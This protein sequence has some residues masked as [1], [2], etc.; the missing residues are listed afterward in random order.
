MRRVENGGKPKG[1]KWWRFFT[2]GGTSSCERVFSSFLG[3]VP[4]LL[5]LFTISLKDD[6]HL[7]SRIHIFPTQPL[8]RWWLGWWWSNYSGLVLLRQLSSNVFISRSPSCFKSSV[9]RDRFRAAGCFGVTASGSGPCFGQSWTTSR[10]HPPHLPE[11]RQIL[12]KP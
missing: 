3:T 2:F 5:L 7:V 9:A 11:G 1:A 12:A 10:R 4:L 8:G 6:Y